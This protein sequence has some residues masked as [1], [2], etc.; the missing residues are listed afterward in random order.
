MR[1]DHFIVGFIV[2]SVII[3]TFVYAVQDTNNNYPTINTS[4][5]EFS[6]VYNTIN[7]TYAISQ[8]MKEQ[9]IDADITD[10]EPWESMTKR[11]Y[12]ALRG[13]KNTFQLVGDIINALA[14]QLHIPAFF[15]KF[16][17]AALSVIVVFSII[18]LVLR[19]SRD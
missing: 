2:F 16:A 8:E 15:I 6:A 7:E 1:L 14:V 17:M 18:Y 13:V 5:E 9:S 4:T 19:I 11:S 10:T 3:V 12:T